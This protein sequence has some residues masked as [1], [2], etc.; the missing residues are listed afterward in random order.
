MVS[1]WWYTGDTTIRFP[2]G[3]RQ[4]SGLSVPSPWLKVD[5]DR[6]RKAPSAYRMRRLL[7]RAGYRVLKVRLDRSPSGRGWHWQIQVSPC[8]RSCMEVVALQAVLGSDPGRESVNIQRAARVDH[9]EV[10]A[11]WR[12]RWNVLYSGKRRKL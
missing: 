3:D 11:F 8:P 5:L 2:K 6:K 9:D 4:H 12:R 1:P 7:K 10:T